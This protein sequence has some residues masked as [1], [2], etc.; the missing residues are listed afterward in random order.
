MGG[1]A[2]AAHAWRAWGAGVGPLVFQYSI[3]F[4]EENAPVALTATP[5]E[6]SARVVQ[7]R[8]RAGQK[9]RDVLSAEAEVAQGVGRTA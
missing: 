6:R 9:E 2:C 4:K 8:E 7:S 1:R 3:G 5:P